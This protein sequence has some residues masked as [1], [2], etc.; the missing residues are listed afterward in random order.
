MFVPYKSPCHFSSSILPHFME[1][2][3]NFLKQSKENPKVLLFAFILQFLQIG[4]PQFHLLEQVLSLLVQE[5]DIL[6]H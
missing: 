2:W 1:K 4:F 5:P 6:H 3:E